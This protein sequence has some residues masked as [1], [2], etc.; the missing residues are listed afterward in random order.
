MRRLTFA[1]AFAVLGCGGN[2]KTTITPVGVTPEG[3]PVY[4]VHT[5]HSDAVPRATTHIAIPPGGAS[6]AK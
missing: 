1:L 4:H 6:P 3:W 5:P 2:S